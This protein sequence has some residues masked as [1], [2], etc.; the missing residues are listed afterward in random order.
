MDS[1]DA[2]ATCRIEWRRS[3]W[4]I[5]LLASLALAS[6]VSPWLSDL[7][8]AACIAADA[9][10]VAY[11]A[12][13]LAREAARR[14]CTLAWAGGE[15]PW[16]V[17]CEGRVDSLRHVDASVRGGLA[18]LTLADEASGRRRRFAWWPDTLDAASRRSLRLV[19]MVQRGNKAT[20]ADG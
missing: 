6:G 18:V 11:A 8:R 20:R 1:F 15:A 7:P 9:V 10:V 4:M 14:P 17:E 12:W 3:R 2:S 13:A 5:A 16:R 19:S